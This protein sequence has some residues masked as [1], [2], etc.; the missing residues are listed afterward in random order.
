M[1][2]HLFKMPVLALRIMAFSG[3]CRDTTSF[4]ST[5]IFPCISENL[6]YLL[7]RQS[8][9]GQFP[10]KHSLPLIISNILTIYLV[11]GS[12]TTWPLEIILFRFF[13]YYFIVTRIIN[14]WL[15]CYYCL[16]CPLHLGSV[17]QGDPGGNLWLA[18][19]LAPPLW[20]SPGEHLGSVK[21]A[22]ATLC[23]HSACTCLTCAAC[24]LAILLSLSMTQ[25]KGF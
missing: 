3:Q 9:I 15:N 21:P 19:S 22:P 14:F 24:S 4:S 10:M 2:S 1:L 20:Q 23:N 16:D 8:Y 12:T 13:Q 5:N 11:Q 6:S 25:C 18:N 7:L 17:S